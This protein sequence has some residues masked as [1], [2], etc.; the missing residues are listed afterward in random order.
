MIPN[1]RRPIFSKTPKEFDCVECGRHIIAFAWY[2]GTP[3][4]CATCLHLPGWH[5]DAELR[6][7]LGDDQRSEASASSAEAKPRAGTMKM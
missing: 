3:L 5:T 2:E 4:I 6:R 7:M 1:S